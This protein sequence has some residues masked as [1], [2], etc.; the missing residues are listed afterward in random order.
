MIIV[1][2][3]LVVLL[4]ATLVLG[5]AFLLTRNRAYWLTIK[6]MYRYAAYFFGL[7]LVVYAISR[8]IRF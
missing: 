8:V 4:L 5:A 3:C 6:K 1:R 2:F 7:A